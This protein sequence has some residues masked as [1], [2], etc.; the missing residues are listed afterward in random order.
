MTDSDSLLDVA[1]RMAASFAQSGIGTTVIGAEAMTKLQQMI[2]R[3]VA[4]FS[5]SLAFIPLRNGQRD[6]WPMRSSRVW[7]NNIWPRD[8]EW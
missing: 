4:V 6:R 2:R 7:G 5:V 8:A 3:T 1:E